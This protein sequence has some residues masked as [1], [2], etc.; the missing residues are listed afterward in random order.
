MILIIVKYQSSH[1][2]YFNN[3]YKITNLQIELKWSSKLRETN[4]RKTP[5]KL[6]AF[7]CLN[8]RPQLHGLEFISN[9]LVR[10]YF[11]LKNYTL[12]QG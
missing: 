2:V 7:R 9:I 6:C 12:L 5:F 1:L 3:S 8:S 11:F 10:N 4:G